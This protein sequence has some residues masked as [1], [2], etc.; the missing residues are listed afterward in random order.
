VVAGFKS[1]RHSAELFEAGFRAADELDAELVV[2]HAWKLAG[3][4]DDIVARRVNES[5]SNRDLKSAIRDLVAPW[6]ES[7][8]RVPVRIK[9]EHEYPV[10]AITEATRDADRLVLVKPL[11][12]SVVHHLGRTARGVLRFAQ[13]PVEVVP[14]KPHDELT[15]PPVVIEREGELLP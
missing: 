6:Q 12:G 11:H 2:F 7:Y 3:R 10:H 15:L 9:V 8:P 5:A 13:C 4:Y 1:A 14:A